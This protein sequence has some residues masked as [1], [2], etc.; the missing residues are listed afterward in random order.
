L[1]AL[2]QTL[3]QARA[4]PVPPGDNAARERAEIEFRRSVGWQA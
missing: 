1:P 4:Q 3:A 2:H